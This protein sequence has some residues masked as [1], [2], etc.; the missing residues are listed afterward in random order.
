[1]LLSRQLKRSSVRHDEDSV[2]PSFDEHDSAIF[3]RRARGKT[4]VVSISDAEKLIEIWRTGC[5]RGRRD[6]PTIARSSS[7]S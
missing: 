2:T 5:G 6:E 7:T 3:D 4:A 1:M